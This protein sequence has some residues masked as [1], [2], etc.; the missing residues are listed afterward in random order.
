MTLAALS[1][2]PL[3]L[4]LHLWAAL[5][6]LLLGPIALYRRRRDI[7]HRVAGYCWVAVM[8]LAAASAFWLE[9]AVLPLA[10][11]FGAIHLLSLVVLHG[12]WR[13]VSAARAGDA[14]AHASWMRGLYWQA[15]IVAGALTLLPGRTLNRLFFPETPAAG[16]LVILL[17]ALAALS[18]LVRLRAHRQ[19]G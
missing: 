7:W 5:V 17:I 12:L 19:A 6:A 1:D 15:L 10:G 16:F 3:A 8:A 14:A 4:H 13:G 18:R 11:G 9:A 2:L